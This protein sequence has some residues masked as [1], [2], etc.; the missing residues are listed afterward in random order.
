[1]YFSTACRTHHSIFF[2][3][4]LFPTRLQQNSQI[5]HSVYVHNNIHSTTQRHCILSLS[6]VVQLYF[7]LALFKNHCLTIL[8]SFW[9][10]YLVNRVCSLQGLLHSYRLPQSRIHPRHHSWRW[11]KTPKVGDPRNRLWFSNF[12]PIRRTERDLQVGHQH[13]LQAS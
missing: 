13:A 5:R 12:L 4:C 9:K 7:G 10:G 8:V 1:M 6:I 3:I 2:R 11:S